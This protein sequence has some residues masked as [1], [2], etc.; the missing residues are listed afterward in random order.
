MRCPYGYR[1]DD[2]NRVMD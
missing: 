1:Y 2:R